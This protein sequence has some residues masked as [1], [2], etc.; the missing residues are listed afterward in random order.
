MA[1]E[2][3]TSSEYIHHHLTNLTFGRLADGHWALANSAEQAKEMGFWAFNVDMLGWSL[4]LVLFFFFLFRGVAKRATSGVPS[5]LQ[6]FVEWM[7]EFVDTSVRGSFSGKNEL[8]APMALTIFVWVFLM[9]FMDLLPIDWLPWTAEK[10]GQH[11]FDK[12]PLHVFFRVVPSADPNITFGLAL[13][14][15]WLMLYYSVKVKGIGGFLG[16]LALQPFSAKNPVI[17]AVFVPINLILELVSLISKPVSLSLRLFGN[18][19]AGETIFILIALM[20]GAGWI[21]GPFGGLLQIAW[22]IFHILI[23]LLQAFIFMV[24]T[25]VYMDMAHQHH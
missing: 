11:V 19:Y 15:F 23:I 22:G 17:Q 14:V 3:L 5:G 25:I 16:E 8:V 10:I 21:M 6:N 7:M 2:T 20:Y 12:D 4:V 9:N 18:M 24:L 13:S 1:S